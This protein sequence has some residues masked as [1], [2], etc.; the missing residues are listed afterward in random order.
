[1]M[2]RY[3]MPWRRAYEAYAGLA[4]MCAMVFFAVVGVAGRLPRPLALPLA[5]LC[6]GLSVL[7]IVQALRTWCCAH[8]FAA[9]ACR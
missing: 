5:L 1:M 9:E 6:F 7:R 3:E 4:W 8:R 2:R